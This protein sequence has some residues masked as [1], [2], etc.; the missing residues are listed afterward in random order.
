MMTDAMARGSK[1]QVFR[2]HC[3]PRPVLGEAGGT[4]E[5]L[6][7][8][9]MDAGGSCEGHMRSTYHYA[10]RS[11]LPRLHRRREANLIRPFTHP[12]RR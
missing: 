7:R 8:S 4:G 5:R 1:Q 3:T 6:L 2:L 11:S 10:L 12:F 9:G